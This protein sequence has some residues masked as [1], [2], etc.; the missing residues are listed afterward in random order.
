MIGCRDQTL[1]DVF[2]LLRAH[3]WA[4]N[5]KYLQIESQA[6]LDPR[7]MFVNWGF[8]VRPTELQ[9]GFG[10]EQ[11]KRFPGFHRQR[12]KMPAISRIICAVTRV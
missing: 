1:S 9:S 7:Y 2:R 3:G 4:R 8:N 11:L 12:L 5:T 10:L 6:G